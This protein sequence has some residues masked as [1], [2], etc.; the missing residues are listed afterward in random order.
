MSKIDD[1]INELKQISPML[2]D[3]KIT[4]GMVTKYEVI[5]R[6]IALLKDPKCIL[7][8]INSFGYG[9]AN[10]LYWTTL[11]LLEE[12]EIEQVDPVLI[13][14]LLYGEKGTRMWAAYMLGRSK[15]VGAVDELISLLK[16]TNEFVRHNATMA[17]GMI[18]EIKARPYLEAIKNDNSNEVRIAVERALNSLC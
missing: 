2:D 10:G 11:H 12:F 5:V 17:L 14:S 15:N 16:D 8:L 9:E 3:N 13:K 18:G 1:L 7:P 4:S 6:E